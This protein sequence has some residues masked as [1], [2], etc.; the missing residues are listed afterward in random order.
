MGIENVI[1]DMGNVLLRFDGMLFSRIFTKDED[2]ARLLNE[3]LFA[4]PSWSLLDAGVIDEDTMERIAQTRL[5]ERLHA[6]LHGALTEWDLHQPPIPG[7]N[8]LARRL[9]WLDRKSVV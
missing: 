8:E 4:H 9:R 1:F 6:A 5:P 2:D 3:A 7:T